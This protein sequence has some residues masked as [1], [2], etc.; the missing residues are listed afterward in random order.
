MRNVLLRTVMPCLLAC[1]CLPAGAQQVKIESQGQAAVESEAMAL[2]AV[3]LAKALGQPP[4]G[5]G[6]I[7]FFRSAKSPG[8]APDVRENGAVLGDLPSGMYFV[9]VAAPGVHAYD[10]AGGNTATINVGSGKTHYVQVIRNRHGNPQL[11]RSSASA[12]QRA[13]K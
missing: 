8:A 5:K 1:L 13:A 10:V 3:A 6:Q 7:V 12:F 2:D 9:A 4:L 11:L